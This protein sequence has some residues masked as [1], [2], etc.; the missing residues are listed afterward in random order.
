M[1][2]SRAAA[3]KQARRL[4]AAMR[5]KRLLNLKRKG[6]RLI[7]DRILKLLAAA[8]LPLQK[9]AYE[10]KL[11]ELL[12][13]SPVEACQPAGDGPGNRRSTEGMK[14]QVAGFFSA[15]ET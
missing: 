3:R 7:P 9:K 15:S 13:P 1:A 10:A 8:E 5:A 12:D 4:K 2:S 6:E 14:H 11:R